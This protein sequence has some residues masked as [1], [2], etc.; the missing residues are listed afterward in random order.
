[1]KIHYV[2]A[3]PRED[4]FNN[5]LCKIAR[6]DT[7]N[8][9]TLT[10]L[11]Q[12]GF[13]SVANWD[14]FADKTLQSSAAYHLAQQAAVESNALSE[15]ILQQVR[16]INTADI[17]ILQFPL[18]W[19]SMP[20]I[21]KGWMD[22]VFVKGIAYNAGKWFDTGGFAGKKAMLVITTHAPET[23][24]ANNGL[25]GP[26][27]E[28]LKP[29]YHS[30]RFVGFTVLKPF[31]AFSVTTNSKEQNNAILDDYTLLLKNISDRE[32]LPFRSIDNFDSKL[33]LKG[34]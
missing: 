20:A 18:W 31:V 21:L 9:L 5:A 29:I 33:Q 28:L 23:A 19:F 2:L 24:F 3:H 4:S 17:V 11:Y 26:I 22:R 16:F 1:M 7:N 8:E 32:I 34:E 14:D 25:N 12:S 30:L 27:D 6:S 15:D 13:K 10:D